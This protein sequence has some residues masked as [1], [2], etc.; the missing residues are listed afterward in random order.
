MGYLTTFTIGNDAL[1]IFKENP[2]EFA[3]ALFAAMEKANRSYRAEDMGFFGYCNYITSQPS[4][5]ADEQ[6]LYI[7]T[8]NTVFNLNPYRQDFEQL[9]KDHPA[10]AEDFVASAERMIKECKAQIKKSKNKSV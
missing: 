4:F 2:K 5:H 7:H 8:G 3:G 1:H 9:L 6:Q 10:T